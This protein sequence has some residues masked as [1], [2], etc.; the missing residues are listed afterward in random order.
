MT[1]CDLFYSFR[2]V[3]IVTFMLDTLIDFLTMNG[4]VL[5]G[6]DSDTNLVTLD[7]EHSHGD[8]VTNHK[9]FTNTSG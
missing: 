4:N 7:T 8:I 3:V 2:T 1:A 9:C 5:G 6:I